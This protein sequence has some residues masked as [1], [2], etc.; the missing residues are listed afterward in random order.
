M[1]SEAKK[2]PGTPLETALKQERNA[3]SKEVGFLPLLRI[4][5]GLELAWARGNDLYSALK[6]IKALNVAVGALKIEVAKGRG[7]DGLKAARYGA[8]PMGE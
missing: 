8:W 3:L 6:D 5:V 7:A 2:L 4:H 1:R